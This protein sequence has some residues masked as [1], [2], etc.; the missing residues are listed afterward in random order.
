MNGTERRT[1]TAEVAIG[2]LVCASA[3]YFGIRPL[4][5]RV[6]AARAQ[7]DALV[8]QGVGA[9][10]ADGMSAEDLRRAAQ[11]I[12]EQA[13][14][15][16]ERGR[17][18]FDEAGMFA[19]L[20]DLA[21]EHEL[22]LEHLQPGPGPALPKPADGAVPPGDVSITYTMTVR[23]EFASI[24]RFLAQLPGRVPNCAVASA[25]VSAAVDPAE[26]PV[27]AI[28]QTNHWA[29]DAMPAARLADAALAANE[30]VR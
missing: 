23:G 4:E 18:A 2:V 12:A 15:L 11:R 21:R 24:G 5:R 19:A 1:L 20:T 8:A 3:W 16:N 17:G 9:R 22:R 28:I 25:R 10:V 26:P 29:F 27:T 30:G 13:R 7:A 6:E 14:A